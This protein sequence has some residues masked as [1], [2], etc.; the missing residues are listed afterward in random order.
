M[1]DSTAF[2]GAAR[3]GE[4]DEF[5]LPEE[6]GQR[7]LELHEE[8]G[9]IAR[10]HGDVGATTGPEELCDRPG[11]V[12]W[13]LHGLDV[14][15]EQEDGAAGRHREIEARRRGF[16]SEYLSGIVL[17]VALVHE[18]E[19]R[20]L[21]VLHAAHGTRPVDEDS[22]VTQGVVLVAGADEEV[23]GQEL[24]VHDPFRMTD[25]EGLHHPVEDPGHVRGRDA[26]GVLV[27]DLLDRPV[28]DREVSDDDAE[29]VVV[30]LLDELGDDHL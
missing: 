30:E 14:A 10:P 26:F 29:A 8:R 25:H 20:P 5:R 24:P 23:A 12:L 17:G 13:H 15:A 28:A 2:S 3:E 4:L 18:G 19:S 22:G 11:D 9:E 27:V 21:V 1:W 6:L 16:A 7:P